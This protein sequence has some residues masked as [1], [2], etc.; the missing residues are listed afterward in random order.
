MKSSE[1]TN[2]TPVSLFVCAFFTRDDHSLSPWDPTHQLSPLASGDLDLTLPWEVPA[3]PWVNWDPAAPRDNWD[4]AAP[5]YDWDPE[6]LEMTEYLLHL[7]LTEYLLHPDYLDH[8]L[9]LMD[10]WDMTWSLEDWLLALFLSWLLASALASALASVLASADC[11][12]EL[13]PLL[14][15]FLFLLFCLG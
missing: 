11:W 6:F 12:V 14:S 4:P 3:A 15:S 7:G 8:P 2:V 9:Y 13:T 10:D 1:V 5:W